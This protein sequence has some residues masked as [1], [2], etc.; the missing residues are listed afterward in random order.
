MLS[1]FVGDNCRF[2]YVGLR[3]DFG[4]EVAPTPTNKKRPRRA[5]FLGERVPILGYLGGFDANFPRSVL[6]NRAS[7]PLVFSSLRIAEYTAVTEL[8]KR[9][10]PLIG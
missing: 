4:A 7:A 2:A 3:R 6:R 5:A 1:E 8:P 9:G 10:L